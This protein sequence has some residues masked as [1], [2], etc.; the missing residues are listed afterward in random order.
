MSGPLGGQPGAAP[1]GARG[2]G[3]RRML[4]KGLKLGSN[5]LIIYREKQNPGAIEVKITFEG[6]IADKRVGW[7]NRESYV[8]LNDCLRLNSKGEIL[9]REGKKRLMDAFIDECEVVE[10]TERWVSA[11]L[12]ALEGGSE[13]RAGGLAAVMPTGGVVGG[14]MPLGMGTVMPMAMPT[15][16]DGNM[17]VGFGTGIPM[18]MGMGMPLAINTTMPMGFAM[19][20][21]VPINMAPGAVMNP[22]LSN[23]MDMATCNPASAPGMAPHMFCMMNPGMV[24]CCSSTAVAATGGGIAS[25]S[26]TTPT[27]ASRS[28]SRGR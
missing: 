18:A 28:R 20:C 17:P 26:T 25:S 12:A 14:M 9:A 6:T 19:P 7:D 4:L 13:K 21:M 10:K 24:N 15:T 2:P 5:V 23:C 1:R 3:K 16:A 27:R 22:P 11:Q 8:E